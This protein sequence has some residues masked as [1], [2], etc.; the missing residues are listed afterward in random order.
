MLINLMI[1][2]H[3]FQQQIP[4]QIKQ[5]IQVN[6][7]IC[8][9]YQIKYCFRNKASSITSANGSTTTKKGGIFDDLQDLLVDQSTGQKISS[10][11]R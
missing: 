7:N 2:Y 5:I 4:I 6:F 10:T 1:V 9:L 11:K 3:F 8:L